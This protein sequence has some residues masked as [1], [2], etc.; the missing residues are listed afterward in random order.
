MHEQLLKYCLFSPFKPLMQLLRK[1]RLRLSR[2]WDE[3]SGFCLWCWE[4]YCTAHPRL[5]LGAR[6]KSHYVLP[7]AFIPPNQWLVDYW[8]CV[9]SLSATK[10]YCAIALALPRGPREVNR[11]LVWWPL[12]GQ[13]VTFE[14]CLF[15]FPAAVAVTVSGQESNTTVMWASVNS[16]I[17]E[18]NCKLI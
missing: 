9:A 17:N 10:K 1:T 7:P 2:R 6:E 13:E 16:Q 8:C 12:C 5:W 18:L 3:N 11:P 4:V 14:A 15:I